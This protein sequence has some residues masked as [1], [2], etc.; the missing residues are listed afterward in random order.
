MFLLHT[1]QGQTQKQNDTY[2]LTYSDSFFIM[3]IDITL[4][5]RKP[6]LPTLPAQHIRLNGPDLNG[7][8]NTKPL[9][10]LACHK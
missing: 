3:F 9:A 6:V 2:N 8:K 4:V 1:I 5:A 7:A 10:S